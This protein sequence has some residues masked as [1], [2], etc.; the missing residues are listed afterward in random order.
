MNLSLYY[1]IRIYTS[2]IS[3][4]SLHYTEHIIA[5]RNRSIACWIRLWK[6][7]LMYSP[8]FCV[9][10]PFFGLISIYLII[11]LFRNY[12][13]WKLPIKWWIKIQRKKWSTQAYIVQSFAQLSWCYCCILGTERSE[14][15]SESEQK[16]FYWDFRWNTGKL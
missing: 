6:I 1:L 16:R 12:F 2:F 3:R 13:R 8:A 9:F 4:C 7:A 15:S 14:R 11:Y 10:G 5:G